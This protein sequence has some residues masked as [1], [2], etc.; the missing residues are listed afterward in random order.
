MKIAIILLYGLYD[1]KNT[2][3]Q[4]YFDF[5]ITEIKKQK[6]DKVILCGGY[7]FPHIENISEAESAKRYLQSKSQYDDYILEDKSINTNQNLEFAS[8]HISSKDDLFVYGDWIRIAKI[9]WI[10]AHFLLKESLENIFNA[11]MQF[12]YKKEPYK[13]FTMKNLTVIGY[14][15]KGKSKEEMVGQ[16]FA[17]LFD[18]ISLYNKDFEK[19]NIDQRKKD[20]GL[21]NS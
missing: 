2:N 14:D 5:L 16:T 4:A 19:Q 20:F 15:F 10:S 17:T 1:P 21:N 6:F 11:M 9:S 18:V 13:P 8:K 7:T 12:V 3:Y